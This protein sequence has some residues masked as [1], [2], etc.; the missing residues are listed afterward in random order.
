MKKFF[1]FLVCLTM[2]GCSIMGA[3]NFYGVKIEHDWDDQN[4]VIYSSEGDSVEY[5]ENKGLNSDVKAWARVDDNNIV[6]R[7][8]NNSFAPIA[9]DYFFDNF[10]VV[11]KDGTAY[12]LKKQSNLL[13]RYNAPETLN[14]GAKAKFVFRMPENILASDVEKIVCELGLL[15][16]VRVVLKP[17]PDRI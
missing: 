10:S 3:Y 6:I 9:A 7:V 15:R 17:V 11:A 14:R 12:P 1:I 2:M 16:G 4:F 13:Y 8:E 5:S